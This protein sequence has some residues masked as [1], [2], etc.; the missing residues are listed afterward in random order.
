[1]IGSS[2]LFVHD[3]QQASIWLIDFAKTV[4]LPGGVRI[5]HSCTWSVG[6]HEDGY[7]IGINN[8]ISIFEEI[9]AKRSALAQLMAAAAPAPPS[10]PPPP[11]M[12][13]T[14]D[15]TV[16]VTACAEDAAAAGRPVE[17]QQTADN[18]PELQRAA[19]SLRLAAPDEEES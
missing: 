4:V 13:T 2:L 17:S 14:T 5:D 10:P 16:Q 11:P 18:V 15:V 7:L 8:L 6:N 3:R 9:T 19:E 1:M 12:Q